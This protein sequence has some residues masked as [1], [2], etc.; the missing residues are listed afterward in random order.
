VKG[1]RFITHIKRLKDCR[2][3]L[4]MFFENASALEEKLFC[5]LWQLPP[6]QKIDLKKLEDFINLLKKHHSGCLH[7]FEF[8]HPTWF[9]EETYQLLKNND[10][11]LCIADSP[12]FSTAEAITSSFVYLRFHGGKVLYGS[13]YSKEELK[14]W[15]EKAKVWL[16]NSKLLFAFFNNDAQG[17]AVKNALKFRELIT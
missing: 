3:S 15:A 7:S 8:R 11:N 10:I 13:E 6:S 5:A 4:K 1:S 14:E 2:D 16:K 17:F 9:K 12:T